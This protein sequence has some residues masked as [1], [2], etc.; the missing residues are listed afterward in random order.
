MTFE[1]VCLAK[2]ELIRLNGRHSVRS[3]PANSLRIARVHTLLK[4]DENP[5][6]KE[7]GNVVPLNLSSVG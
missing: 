3:Q 4:D 6:V 5:P 7:G 1:I 2:H